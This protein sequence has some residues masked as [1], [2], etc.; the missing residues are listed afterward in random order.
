[1]Q[2]V[3]ELPDEIATQLGDVQSM[4]QRLTE[5]IIVDAYRQGK[6]SRQQV[7]QVLRRDHWQTEDLLLQYGAKRPYTLSDLEM[8][9]D[10]LAALERK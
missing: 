5:A 3:I 1:M 4:S 8:D 9:R 6:L 10:A 2:I 7:A